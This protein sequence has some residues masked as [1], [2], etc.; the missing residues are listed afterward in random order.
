M[1]K[2]R[3]KIE[4]EKSGKKWYTAQVCCGWLISFIWSDI[5]SDGNT[6]YYCGAT[7]QSNIKE[8][9]EAINKRRAYLDKLDS[10]TI[11]HIE[12]KSI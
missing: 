10:E 9:E 8:A 5:G 6:G 1:G 11:I 12:Y 2:Y 7:R 4:T 3:I